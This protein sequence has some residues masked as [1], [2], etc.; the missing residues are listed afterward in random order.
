MK[1]YNAKNL[2]YRDKLAKRNRLFFILKIS[3]LV[4]GLFALVGGGV[5][6]LFFTGNLEIKDITINGLQT[7]DREFVMAEINKQFENKK[8]GYLDTQRNIFFFDGKALEASLLLRY[9]VLKTVEIGKK[10]PHQLAIDVLERKSSGIWC[11]SQECRYFDDE[12]QTWGPA[13]RSSGFLLLTVEDSRPRE[14]FAID[15]DFFRAI[16]E[17]SANLSQATIKSAVIPEDS[18]DEFRIYTDKS[19]YIIFSLGTN[20]KSQLEVLKIFLEERSRDPAFNPQYID[21]RIEERV[22]FR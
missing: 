9:P 13:V 21:L 7:V 3:V 8:F 14:G 12:M 18:F 10:L 2:S 4:L 6:F 1:S 5:Y 11:A 22:Y 19:F 20:I 17:V 15:A 16:L